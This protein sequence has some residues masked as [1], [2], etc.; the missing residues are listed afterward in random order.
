MNNNYLFKELGD[1]ENFEPSSLA[2]NVSFTQA[3]FYGDWQKY[4]NREVKRFVI[5]KDGVELA[6]FQLIK[7]PLIS[8]WSYI[9]LPYGPVTKNLSKELLLQIKSEL[10][11]IAKQ[12]NA[13]FVRLDF[14]PKLPAKVPLADEI[15]SSA[16][17]PL[18]AIIGKPAPKYTYHSAYFQPRIEWYIKLD[19]NEDD[20]YKSMHENNRYSIRL[21]QRKEIVT[22]IISQNFENY[23]EIFYE[24]MA[25]TS[26]RNNFSLHPKEYYK[27]ILKNLKK[28]DGF[29]VIAKYGDK[30]LAIDLIIIYSGIANYVFAC[31]S[32]EE[33]NR[34]PSY[35]AIWT[36]IK[37]SKLLGCKYFN[38]GGISTDD[39]PN[40]N[41]EGLTNFKKKFGGEEVRHSEFFDLIVNPLIYWLYNLRKFA[42]SASSASS[43]RSKLDQRN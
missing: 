31:S 29:L 5:T 38:F 33:R 6:Y 10:I 18:T 9:Y 24:L 42:K 40:K 41:W 8:R 11:K 4:L 7:Y 43:A 17:V 28:D 25:I 2:E 3:K 23:T 39:Q 27:T 37:H 21:S 1:N 16:K 36:A 34:A 20:L 30:V 15:D 14:T 12:M 22:E 19:K 13:V 32:N 35:A 26:K